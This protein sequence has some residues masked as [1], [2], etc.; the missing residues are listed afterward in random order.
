MQSIYPTKSLSLSSGRFCCR[1]CCCCCYY[2]YYCC[3][4]T[5]KSEFQIHI[6][7]LRTNTF[8]RISGRS[9]VVQYNDDD[10]G[11]FAKQNAFL[12][13]KVRVFNFWKIFYAFYSIEEP[14]RFVGGAI[15]SFF[16]LNA[17]A[18]F[19]VYFCWMLLMMHFF[20]IIIIIIIIVK[21][22]LT[23]LAAQYRTN[24]LDR[25]VMWMHLELAI[26]S[27]FPEH[28]EFSRISFSNIFH[29][30]LLFVYICISSF[31]FQTMPQS[32]VVVVVVVVTRCRRPV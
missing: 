4:P 26:S 6:L 1:C 14:T 27:F 20:P 32:M 23:K 30:I 17:S 9:V 31:P 2:C 18:F 12:G 21:S 3:S 13:I 16:F 19:F 29:C 5:H 8:A 25:Y 7:S 10:V 22:L 24:T 28:I 11:A 15:F